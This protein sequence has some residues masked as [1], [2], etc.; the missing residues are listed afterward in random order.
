MRSRSSQLIT[1][2]FHFIRYFNLMLFI[3]MYFERV[4][5]RFCS[6]KM[7]TC[8]SDKMELQTVEWWGKMG[9]A[10]EHETNSYNN[11]GICIFC[12]ALYESNSMCLNVQNALCQ[13]VLNSTRMWP[14][15]ENCMY[16]KMV[17]KQTDENEKQIN[18]DESI[19]DRLNW[20]EEKQISF[21]FSLKHVTHSADWVNFPSFFRLIRLF[22]IGLCQIQYQS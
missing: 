15:Q 13:I 7:L 5:L 6:V 4:A 9:G 8:S 14:D 10:R 19:S 11:L 12:V 22:Y 18:T 21:F 17:S 2:P 16:G 3:F 1:H 20:I